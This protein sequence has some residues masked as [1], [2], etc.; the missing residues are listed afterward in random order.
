MYNFQQS[1]KENGCIYLTLP[2][3]VLDSIIILYLDF[4]ALK[5]YAKG[6]F[7]DDIYEMLLMVPIL[8][9]C[10]LRTLMAFDFYL[11][12]FYPDFVKQNWDCNYRLIK[13]HVSLTVTQAITLFVLGIINKNPIT[14]TLY[15]ILAALSL[16]SIPHSIILKKYMEKYIKD[17][18]RYINIPSVSHLNLQYNQ[19]RYIMTMPFGYIS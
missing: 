10:F 17:S 16:M 13:S 19:P 4:I 7:D 9:H 6:I 15:I 2:F 8:P 3:I 5:A 18:F 1:R 14:S 12:L 11:V